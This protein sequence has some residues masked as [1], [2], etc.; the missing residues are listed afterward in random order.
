MTKQKKIYYKLTPHGDKI[1]CFVTEEE[2][3]GAVQSWVEGMSIGYG[4]D[5]EVV[6]MT[7]EKF[8][9]MPEYEP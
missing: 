2:V 5:V 7:E 8:E 4:L 9:K 3:G 1:G 6:E